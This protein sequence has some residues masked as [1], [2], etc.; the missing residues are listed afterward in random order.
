MIKKV[1]V[2]F[3]VVSQMVSFGH[4]IN[5]Y[6][7]HYV[8]YHI[9]KH[10]VEAVT[11]YLAANPNNAD[12]LYMLGNIYLRYNQVDFAIDCMKRA[13]SLG[14]VMA[15]NTLGDIYYSDKNDITSAIHYYKK[16]A[17]KGYGPSQF[18]LGIIYKKHIKNKRKAKHWLYKAS[19]NSGDFDEHVRKEALK[20][21]K[22]L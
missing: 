12:A 6:I 5:K 1:A 2:L 8:T 7:S 3:L 18:N 16:G 14:C 22:E 13:D 4:G 11:N 15:A 19:K 10:N 20:Y 9:E 17:R 21:Y